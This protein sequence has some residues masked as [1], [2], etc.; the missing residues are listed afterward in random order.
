MNDAA[1]LREK[2]ATLTQML[3]FRTIGMFGHVSVRRPAPTSSTIS[4]N[5]VGWISASVP[6]SRWKSWTGY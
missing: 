1:L 5:P 3:N 2:A 4:V 6:P